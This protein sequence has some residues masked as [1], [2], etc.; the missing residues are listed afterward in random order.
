MM[1]RYFNLLASLALILIGTAMVLSGLHIIPSSPGEASAA[2]PGTI[3]KPAAQVVSYGTDKDSYARGDRANGF[4]DLKNTGDSVINDVTVSAKVSRSV[5][6]LGSLSLGSKDFKISNMDIQPGK[7]RRA[8]FTVDI[9]KE[10]SGISTAGS[11]DI[12]G[13]VFV[14]G[15]QAGS[16]SK[17]I[18]VV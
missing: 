14:N 15:V 4:I 18:K 8:T 16:F 9:P 13:D 7:T 11:Y 3:I 17:H 5:P 6:I 2:T 1:R 10:F 12:S